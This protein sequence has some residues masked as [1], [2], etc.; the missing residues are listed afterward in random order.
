MNNFVKFAGCFSSPE[1]FSAFVLLIG[2][3]DQMQEFL[4]A[5]DASDYPLEE[6]VTALGALDDWLRDKNR[7][8][9][10]QK[11]IGYVAC[12]AEA[13]SVFSPLPPLE[14]VTNDMIASHGID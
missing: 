5:V 3:A 4:K 2:N 1:Q 12:C 13:V 11:R 6:W 8:P 7:N 10:I 9:S 14:D